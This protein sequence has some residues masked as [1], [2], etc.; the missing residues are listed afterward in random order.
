MG[1][2]KSKKAKGKI[3]FQGAPLIDEAFVLTFAFFLLPCIENYVR[4]APG[5][6][7]LRSD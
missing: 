1:Q 2:G 5:Q 3:V 4:R 7:S 6:L